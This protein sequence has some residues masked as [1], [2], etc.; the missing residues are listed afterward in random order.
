MLGGDEAGTKKLGLI[1]QTG[2]D[3]WFLNALEGVGLAAVWAYGRLV[4]APRGESDAG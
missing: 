4:R 2:V 1:R 3:V